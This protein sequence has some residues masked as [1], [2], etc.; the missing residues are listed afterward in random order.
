VVCGHKALA[1]IKRSSGTVLG[2]K[3]A[4]AGLI[5]GYYLI[6]SNVVA[7]IYLMSS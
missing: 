6:L 4:I 5:V 2:R 1:E 3:R 7:L